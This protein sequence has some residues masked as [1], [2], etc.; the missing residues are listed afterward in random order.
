MGIVTDSKAPAEKK[1][2]DEN[3]VYKIHKLFLSADEDTV[4]RKKYE[5][6]GLSY[7]EAKEMLLDAILSHMKPMREKYEYYQAHPKEVEAIL[8]KG[9]EK[10]RVKT[11]TTIG[12][13]REIVGLTK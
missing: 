10:A 13:V 2:P 11:V 4:V 6:G 12:D 1:N 8:E 3:N 5:A 9:A 7:K